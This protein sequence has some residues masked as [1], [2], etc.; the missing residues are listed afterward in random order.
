MNLKSI[1]FVILLILQAD[2]AFGVTTGRDVTKS[3]SQVLGGYEKDKK[4]GTAKDWDIA[5][6]EWS[7]FKN[8][9]ET[10]YFEYEGEQ[11]V[12][13]L[14]IKKVI[15]KEDTEIE[16]L[17]SILGLQDRVSVKVLKDSPK[18]F[19]VFEI[20][21]APNLYLASRIVHSINLLEKEK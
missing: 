20:V 14:R 6:G 1:I 2:F 13:I 15:L 9:S 10:T 16:D 12:D 18:R 19:W 8:I 17:K 21:Y 11:R 5:E 4:F 3:V 7:R